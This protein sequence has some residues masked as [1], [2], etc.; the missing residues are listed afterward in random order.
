[1]AVQY[2]HKFPKSPNNKAGAKERAE[3]MET[4]NINA[5]NSMSK[6]TN[7]TTNC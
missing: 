7:T 1:M 3:F 2:V 6:P 5:K 4:P